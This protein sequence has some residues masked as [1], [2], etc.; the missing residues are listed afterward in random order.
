[1]AGPKRG[2]AKE[3][4]DTLKLALTALSL[5]G[6]GA[7][8]LGFS[9]S[10]RDSGDA[11]LASETAPAATTPAGTPAATALRTPTP[12]TAAPSATSTGAGEPPE[13]QPT[14]ARPKRS[15]GS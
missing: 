11:M 2:F 4:H 15:R 9:G 7:A 14:F 6:F 12:G 13:P 8:W 1:L 5:A 10:H 3:R